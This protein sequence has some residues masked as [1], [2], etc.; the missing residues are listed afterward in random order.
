M[1]D[2]ACCLSFCIADWELF[3]FLTVDYDK[4]GGGPVKMKIEQA[5]IEGFVSP[6]ERGYFQFVAPCTFFGTPFV[7]E[8]CESPSLSVNASEYRNESVE[9]S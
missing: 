8:V 7:Q 4:E 1:D 2:N 9:P 3:I 6:Q 5:N